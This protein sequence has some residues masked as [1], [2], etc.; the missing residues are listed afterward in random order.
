MKK[1]PILTAIGILFLIVLVSNMMN[2]GGSL[3]K[4]PATTAKPKTVTASMVADMIDDVFKKNFAYDYETALDEKE[5]I[6]TINVWS[7]DINA[8]AIERTKESGKLTVWN[9]MVS[10]LAS[11][12]STAQ[13]AFNENGHDEIVVVLNL[14]DPDDHSTRFLTIANGIAGYDVINDIDLLNK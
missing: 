5:G 1:H 12:V 11:T 4:T 7:P 14:C 6:F 8:D 2:M 13:N 3:P 10:D 9:N